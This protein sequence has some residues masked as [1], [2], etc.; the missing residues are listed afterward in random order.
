MA[1]NSGTAKL[2]PGGAIPQASIHIG[3]AQHS[4]WRCDLNDVDGNSLHQW[5]DSHD[6][7]FSLLNSPAELVNKKEFIR[8]WISIMKSTNDPD[9]RVFVQ[10]DVTQNGSSCM[11]PVKVDDKFAKDKHVYLAVVEVTF[12]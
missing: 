9:E 8:F 5:T 10:V 6:S 2:D 12:A 11:D 3:F 7:T 1:I 4:L